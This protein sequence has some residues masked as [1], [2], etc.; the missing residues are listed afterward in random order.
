MLMHLMCELFLVDLL[1]LL[2]SLC[3]FNNYLL[4]KKTFN[5]Q[6]LTDHHYT[7]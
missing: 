4:K 5:F 7:N 2:K 1:W 3:S 6:T